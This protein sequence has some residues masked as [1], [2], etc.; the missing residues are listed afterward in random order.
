MY[1]RPGGQGSLNSKFNNLYYKRLPRLIFF[2]II[3]SRE[4]LRGGVELLS[5]KATIDATIELEATPT[6]HVIARA[7]FT[8]R[9]APRTLEIFATSSSQIQV[10]T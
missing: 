8:L 6:N 10:K 5:K 2:K 7:G 1:D 3:L 9:G 4:N